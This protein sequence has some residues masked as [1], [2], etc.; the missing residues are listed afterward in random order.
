MESTN[1]YL[2]KAYVTDV[3]DGDTITVDIDLGFWT[4]IRKQK[5]RLF[6]INAPEL[7]GDS[8]ESGLVSKLWLEKMVLGKSIILESIKD[9][10]EKY[11]R[12]LGII[13]LETKT[14]N[15]GVESITYLNINDKMIESG[16]AERY[17]I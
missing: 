6:G 16:L 8:R 5:I 3:Y 14:I 17:L 15:E 1:F 7:K 9:K 4:T 10:S 13:Y 11:G 12:L 2:Y